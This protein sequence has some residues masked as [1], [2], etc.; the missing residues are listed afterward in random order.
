MMFSV[1][2][3]PVGVAL[4]AQAD[5]DWDVSGTHTVNFNYQGTDYAHEVT[6]NQDASDNLTGSGQ[7]G[8]YAW[9]IMS[10]SVDGDDIEFWANYTATADAVTP[11]TV[12]HVEGTID[13]D[14][15]ISGTWS[16]NY[17]GGDR[18]GTFAVADGAAEENVHLHAED[19]GV[20][21]YDTGLGQLKGYSAGF[22]L[23]G[24]DFSDVDSVVV[25]LY[26]GD[27]LLQTNTALYPKFDEITGDQISS[28]F[29]VSGTFDYAADG[30]WDNDR[31][32]QYGQSVAA[33]KVVATVTL[34][35]GTVL[36]AVNT[37]LSGDPTTIYPEIEEPEEPTLTKEACMNGGWKEFSNPSYKNQGQCIKAA[38]QANK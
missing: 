27:T 16:D 5:T 17:Q 1:L 28:P 14:G 38:N 15:S 11:L 33:T 26:A 10:G 13:S 2:A 34:E 19:F 25:K 35:D 7:S 6:L 9:V 23:D 18:S 32:S 3:L 12:M 22:G 8:A 30:Y 36:T 20:V 29:D 21:N 4:T 24:A 31:E 37:N